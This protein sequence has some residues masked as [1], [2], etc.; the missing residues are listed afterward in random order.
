[1]TAS[2]AYFQNHSS[3]GLCQCALPQTDGS[4]R[5][6]IV[7]CHWSGTGGSL[8]RA[9][10]PSQGTMAVSGGVFNGHNWDNAASFYWVGQDAMDVLPW[11]G[12]PPQ[13]RITWLQ[14]SIVLRLRIPHLYR[15][16]LYF[17]VES[18]LNM[19]TCLNRKTLAVGPDVCRYSKSCFPSLGGGQ[20][21]RQV[22]VFKVTG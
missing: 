16:S 13:Q 20:Q 4:G 2:K 6:W 15:Y 21:I 10:L 9:S 12:S 8:W 11:D 14:I 22:T 3:K 17:W 5:S 18:G 19:K 1:M 7:D